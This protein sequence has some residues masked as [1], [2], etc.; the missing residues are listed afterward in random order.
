MK[1]LLLVLASTALLGGCTVP[2]LLNKKPAGLDI[3]TTPSST[4]FLNGANV[5]TTPYSNKTASAGSYTVKLVPTDSSGALQPYETKVTLTPSVSTVISHTFAAVDTDTAGY[6]LEL[7]PD[8]AGKTLLS[9]ISDP[10]TVNVTVD[11]APHGF[12]PLSNIDVTAGSHQISVV[13]PG[14][15]QQD[16]AVNTVKGYNLIIN[17]KLA[18]QTISLSPA[19]VASTSA[20]PTPSPSATPASL[21]PKVASS[22]ADNIK[23]PYVVVN[24]TGTGW[25][26]VRKDASAS[27]AELGKA[28]IGE[29]LPYLGVTTDTGWFKVQFE[30]S[31]G[32]VSG[33]YI[34]LVK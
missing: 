5:G 28:N 10:D 34:T 6:I 23:P 29:K 1:K 30:G 22:A 33:Q 9:V 24:Q 4:V 20:L 19:P 13:S 7:Q 2:S 18:S 14:Y 15:V 27:S 25:L 8:P 17:V 11:G 12:T 21:Q 16:I 26:R 3:E 32:Y 31:P